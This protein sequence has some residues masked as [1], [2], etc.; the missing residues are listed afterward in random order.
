MLAAMWSE[1]DYPAIAE[2]TTSLN[3]R[4]TSAAAVA[5]RNRVDVG[6]AIGNTAIPLALSGA[7]VV[8]ADISTS[9]FA[10]GRWRALE[11]GARLDWL[12]L[13]GG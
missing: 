7:E 10:A 11:A 2:R 6:A 8:A 12:E 3:A 9:Q 5:R 13:D 4:L 1:G